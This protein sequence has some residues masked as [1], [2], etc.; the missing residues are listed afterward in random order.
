MK[1]GCGEALMKEFDRATSTSIQMPT[2][3]SA[4]AERRVR[5]LQRG[6]VRMVQRGAYA[7]PVTTYRS[8]VTSRCKGPERTR[9]RGLGA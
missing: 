4:P 5:T 7:R 3:S 2:A 6:R 1:Q 8:W 9:C